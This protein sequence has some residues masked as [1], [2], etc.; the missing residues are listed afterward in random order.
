MTKYNVYVSVRVGEYWTI[1]A[2]SKA[3]AKA[4]ALENEDVESVD[5]DG[6]LMEDIRVLEVTK[7][8]ED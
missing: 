7:L 6:M 4:K 8:E 1:E 3:E 2:K 5:N